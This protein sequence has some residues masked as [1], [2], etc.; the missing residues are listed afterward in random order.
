[1]GEMSFSNR[2]TTESRVLA[3]KDGVESKKVVLSEDA[4]AIGLLLET[5]SNKMGGFLGR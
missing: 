2:Y 1:M 5:L 3:D 4:M